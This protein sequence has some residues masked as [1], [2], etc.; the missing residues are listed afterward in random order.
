MA[1]SWQGDNSS[2]REQTGDMLLHF[3]NGNLRLDGRTNVSSHVQLYKAAVYA[4]EYIGEI[5]GSDLLIGYN[6]NQQIWV[7]IENDDGNCFSWG[8][9][10]TD[11]KV[12]VLFYVLTE[13][14]E[15]LLYGSNKDFFCYFTIPQVD[16][17]QDRVTRIPNMHLNTTY[18]VLCELLKQTRKHEFK[19][20]PRWFEG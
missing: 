2:N 6:E 7:E 15:Y 19:V 5:V 1:Q 17:R 12:I 11:R 8:N 14:G 3:V 18:Q 9:W 16:P 13:D 20:I 10:D 4:D